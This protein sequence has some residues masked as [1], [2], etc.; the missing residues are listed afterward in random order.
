MSFATETRPQRVRDFTWDRI[1]F[2]PPALLNPRQVFDP[3][4]YRT[5]TL[6]RRPRTS[7]AP[8]SR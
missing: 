8:F 5:L 1:L 6:P 2:Q 4:P 3:L 7:R